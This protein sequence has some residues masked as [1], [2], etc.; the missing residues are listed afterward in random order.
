MGEVG[1]KL[2]LKHRNKMFLSI[3]KVLV[4]GAVPGA[5]SADGES[6]SRGI[7]LGGGSAQ[8]LCPPRQRARLVLPL[9]GEAWHSAARRGVGQ[10]AAPRALLGPPRRCVVIGGGTAARL[11]ETWA[12]PRRREA[13]SV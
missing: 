5:P 11:L 9:C 7:A 13:A 2:V 4:L 3:K 8:R 12:W 1:G 10:D 6:R